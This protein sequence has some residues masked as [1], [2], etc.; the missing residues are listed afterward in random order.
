MPAH[1]NRSAYTT[2]CA[3]VALLAAAMAFA[4]PARAESER[5]RPRVETNLRAGTE[6]SILMTEVW[7]PLAQ[8]RDKVIYADARL[9]GDDGDHREWNLGLGYRRLNDSGDAVVGLHGWFDRRRTARGAVFHQITGG[10]EY[11]GHD[12]DVRLN[13]YAPFDEEEHFA[14]A[15]V[16]TAPYL[17]D[18]GIYYDTF[19]GNLVEKPLRGADL[20]FSI[21]VKALE[22]TFDSFRISAG[23]FVFDSKNTDSLHGLRL[24]AAA[25][26]TPDF[27]IGARFETD[28]RR[29]AQGFAEATLRFPF[30]AKASAKTLGL[31]SRL[32]ESPER[33]VDVITSA[34]VTGQSI[35]RN[36]VTNSATLQEQRVFHV[37]NTAAAGG[38][39]SLAMPFNTL[40]AANAVADRAGDIIYIHRGDGTSGGLN[41]GITLTQ[42]GQAV[43]GAAVDFIYD[44]DRFT[45]ALGRD[46][47]GTVL[48]P[49]D[50]GAPVISNTVGNGVQVNAADVLLSGFDVHDANGAGIFAQAT[51]GAD[52]G[53]LTIHKINLRTNAS[54]NI[55]LG[56]VGAGSRLDANIS[57]ITSDNSIIGF[58]LHTTG[59]GTIGNLNITRFSAGNSFVGLLIEADGNMGLIDL[60][61]SFITNTLAGIFA[62]TDAGTTLTMRIQDTA[63]AGN[64]N[65]LSLT[66]SSGSTLIVDLGGGILGSSG[67]NKLDNQN[68][69]IHFDTDNR[70]LKAE[71]NWWGDPAGMSAA[72]NQ[73]PT[74]GSIDGDP[75]LTVDPLP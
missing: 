47:T 17:A 33:D 71:N 7:I 16:S 59:G 65:G 26:I 42:A 75:W 14:I 68:D 38:D 19:T 58:D 46:F 70:E 30:G 35:I 64:A 4:S 41:T 40:A 25:D 36:A 56:A 24:R 52:L 67:G 66:E 49:A 62:L 72:K 13:G 39:G 28:N 32:D 37:D 57:D 2:S 1:L 10:F 31:R 55:S 48:R 15:G 11:L 34:K 9:M 6:R 5:F 53:T 20:E 54:G 63:I 74:G 45:A 43:I 73:L 3:L 50:I 18:T 61:N 60:S 8:E 51:G 27:R 23:G 21:P 29:G 69:N 12:L 22:G 44:S